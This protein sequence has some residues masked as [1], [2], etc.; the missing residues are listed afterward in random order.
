MARI[1]EL[2]D[3][4][5]PTVMGAETGQVCR[6]VRERMWELAE[7]EL[8]V[9]ERARVEAHVQSCEACARAL[10]T[11]RRARASLRPCPTTADT[12]VASALAAA[13]AAR[14]DRGQARQAPAG[15]ARLGS[16]WGTAIALAACALAAAVSLPLGPVDEPGARRAAVVLTRTT[17]IAA[18][19]TPP[20]VVEPRQSAVAPD[21]KPL[22][23]TAPRPNVSR[24]KVRARR[25]PRR[26]HGS[27]VGLKLAQSP[28]APAPV[29]AP[30]PV[31]DGASFPEYVEPVMVVREMEAS[32]PSYA[33]ARC[34]LPAVEDEDAATVIEITRERPRE[35]GPVQ[36]T[37]ALAAAPTDGEAREELVP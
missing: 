15:V 31:T 4:K 37:L 5:E 8:P 1:T 21:R 3:E 2:S 13:V 33:Y 11:T 29:I 26:L 36:V 19:T 7:R 17:P 27:R 35:D 14:L 25:G 34:V 18:N 16:R 22:S 30:S 32:A 23:A 6:R 12:D 20:L 9:A 24:S 28:L 10:E